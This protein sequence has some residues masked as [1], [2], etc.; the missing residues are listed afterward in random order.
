VLVTNCTTTAYHLYF[1][2][3]FTIPTSYSF[4]TR[5]NKN[6]ALF[7]Y[8]CYIYF[9]CCFFIILR[10]HWFFIILIFLG[11]FF[12]LQCSFA[13]C[14]SLFS[15]CFL[16]C[17]HI[18]FSRYSSRCFFLI[19]VSVAYFYYCCFVALIEFFIAVLMTYYPHCFSLSLLHSLLTTLIATSLHYSLLFSS[20]QYKFE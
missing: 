12:S 2:R 19:V 10:F 17:Y 4:T 20:K 5:M 8:L 13:F 16:Y 6:I 1:H 18:A 15:S 7:F 11:F 14:L 9:L 3:T